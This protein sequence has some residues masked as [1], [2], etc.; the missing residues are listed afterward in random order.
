MNN[1][2]FVGVIENNSGFADVKLVTQ[3][4]NKAYAFITHY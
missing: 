3:D 4:I 2:I 1:V